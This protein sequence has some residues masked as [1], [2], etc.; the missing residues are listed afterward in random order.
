MC[1]GGCCL[2]LV[3]HC[4]V[5]DAAFWARPCLSFGAHCVHVFLCNVHD[6]RE[7]PQLP[8]Q[9]KYLVGVAL[10]RQ[11]LCLFLATADTRYPV[12][13]GWVVLRHNIKECLQVQRVCNLHRSSFAVPTIMLDGCCQLCFQITH[14]PKRRFCAS[15]EGKLREPNVTRNKLEAAC[16]RAILTLQTTTPD[17]VADVRSNVILSM[18]QPGTQTKRSVAELDCVFSVATTEGKLT[19]V[20]EADG[21]DHINMIAGKDAVAALMAAKMYTVDEAGALV[22]VRMR[23]CPGE[24]TGNLEDRQRCMLHTRYGAA[25]MVCS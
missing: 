25:L 16:M 13:S 6:T 2:R 23:F 12:E 21:T 22:I 18:L 4:P 19:V 24:N 7:S 14:A 17:V 11:L 9:A 5:P 8:M 15:C 3:L 1:T 10:R 20:V